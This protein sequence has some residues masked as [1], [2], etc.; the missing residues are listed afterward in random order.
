[1]TQRALSCLNYTSADPRLPEGHPPHPPS[2]E[3]RTE[4]GTSRL[5][6]SRGEKA[7][8]R[9][10]A[11][12]TTEK[13]NRRASAR[14]RRLPSSKRESEARAKKT[15]TK[16]ARRYG[17]S[18]LYYYID[19]RKNF[20]L[21]IARSPA[22]RPRGTRRMSDARS[23][24]TQPKKRE[25]DSKGEGAKITRLRRETQSETAPPPGR[26]GRRHGGPRPSGSGA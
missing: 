16:R 4:R 2:S 8:W 15:K 5:S 24:P 10:G 21:N 13:G 9:T 12:K 20:C 11:S 22:P 6:P 19:L 1:M 3:F 25:N 7:A 18:P 17:L 14:P 23:A 26:V